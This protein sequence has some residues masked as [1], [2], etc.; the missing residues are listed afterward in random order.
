M[1]PEEKKIKQREYQRKYYD[2]NREK[3]RRYSREKSREKRGN[4]LTGP[5]WQGRPRVAPWCDGECL[6]CHY[7]DCIVPACSTDLELRLTGKIIP[8]EGP[9]NY[10]L[11][12]GIQLAGD[13]SVGNRGDRI[14]RKNNH[15]P[16]AEHLQAEGDTDIQPG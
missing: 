2:K 8:Y 12:E 4:G 14:A 15:P 16:T 10:E 5:A 7:P 6:S 11:E 9:R 3:L 1:T 13:G